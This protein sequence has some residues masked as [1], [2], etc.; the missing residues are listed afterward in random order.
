LTSLVASEAGASTGSPGRPALVLANADESLLV[1]IPAKG[2][3]AAP[4]FTKSLLVCFMIDPAAQN[5]TND[6]IRSKSFA[7]MRLMLTTLFAERNSEV[8][9]VTSSA[10]AFSLHI[11]LLKWSDNA[12]EDAA[13]SL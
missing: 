11:E 1:R 13:R 12:V 2:K 6:K 3:V 10:G 8:G 5:R 7:P 9:G 4:N